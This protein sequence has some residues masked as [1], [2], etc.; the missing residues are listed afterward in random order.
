MKVEKIDHIGI[1]VRDLKKA[2]EGGYTSCECKCYDS[3]R[4]AG[5]GGTYSISKNESGEDSCKKKCEA[6]KH[7]FDSC[8]LKAKT[9]YNCKCKKTDGTTIDQNSKSTDKAAC[10][11]ECKA[12]G[13]KFS[14]ESGERALTSDEIQG[15]DQEK[16]YQEELAKCKAKA[17]T[18]RGIFTRGLS[19]LCLGCGDCSQCDIFQVIT[20]I[21]T[22]IFSIAGAL[23]VLLIVN[24]AFGYITAGGNQEAREKAKKGLTAVVIGLILIIV[25]W[26][27][28]NT[29]L[30]QMLGYKLGNWFAPNLKC[31]LQAT[32][33]QDK[34]INS[35]K[36]V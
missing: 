36:L 12:A 30:T 14:T 27:I 29:I 10:K 5:V 8:N 26:V 7:K 33:E 3:K 34:T 9:Y 16:A 19:D 31:D 1:R 6:A 22:Y 2:T 32:A 11:A 17:P 24:G 28:I 35:D 20:S 23:A 13:H 21:I 25:A 15:F 4:Y 18:E